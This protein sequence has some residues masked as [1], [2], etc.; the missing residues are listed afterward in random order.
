MNADKI[1][2]AA[3]AATS[4]TEVGGKVWGR[5]KRPRSPTATDD[6]KAKRVIKE[7]E[8]TIERPLHD[9]SDYYVS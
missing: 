6:S 8:P 3:N 2:E 5:G 4:A 7:F 9:Y 1:N